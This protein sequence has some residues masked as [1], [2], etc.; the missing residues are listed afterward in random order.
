MA[1]N[2]SL[3][4]RRITWGDLFNDTLELARQIIASG[5][6]PELLL[7]VARGGLV[8]GRILSD[9]LSVRDIANVSVKFYKGVGLASDK[10]V[11]A[12]GLNPGLVAGKAVLVVDDIVDSGST[13][14][15]VLEH[16]SSNEPRGVKSAALYVKPWAKIYPDFYVRTVEEWIVFPYEIRETLES[17]PSGY[18]DALGIDPRVLEEIR[19]I[20]RK[21]SVDS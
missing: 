7:V 11:I 8:V 14:Q 21:K 15:A 16:L 6:H 18:E 10:P 19:D 20:I 12:E 13:L 1:G 17:I 3:K 5:Y 9:L 4:L 2:A